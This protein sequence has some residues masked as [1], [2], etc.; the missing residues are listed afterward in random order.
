[1]WV[2]D[3]KHDGRYKGR[4]VALGNQLRPH[5]GDPE[6]AS[7][8]A[9][10]LEFRTIVALSTEMEWEMVSYDVTAAYLYGQ[11]PAHVKLFMRPPTGYRVELPP[12]DG[13]VVAL[14]LVKGLY[15]LPFSGRLWHDEFAAYLMSS[16]HGYQRDPPRGYG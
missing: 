4:L 10:Q 7:P 6:S 5:A 12:K 13:F 16:A 14:R 3:I 15:G 8:T 2:F 11:V 9:G 1:M